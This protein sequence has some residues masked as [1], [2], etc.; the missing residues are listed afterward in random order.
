MEEREERGGGRWLE[1]VGDG[2]KG[3]VRDG[4][5]G[6]WAVGRRGGIGGMLSACIEV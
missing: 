3:R 2:E 4:K 1:C 6:R 5:D